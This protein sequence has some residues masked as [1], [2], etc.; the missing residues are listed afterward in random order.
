M[1]GSYILWASE[2]NQAPPS[3]HRDF[4]EKKVDL[5]TNSAELQ[6]PTIGPQALL[7]VQLVSR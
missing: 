2:I 6:C 5:Q 4:L 1:L 3:A 7:A